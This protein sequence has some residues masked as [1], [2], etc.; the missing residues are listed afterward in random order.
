MKFD[1]ELS[2]ESAS[3]IKIFPEAS[4]SLGY[5]WMGILG[6]YWAALFFGK[7]D[8]TSQTVVKAWIILV[9]VTL[10]LA[11]LAWGKFL[12]HGA[13]VFGATPIPH[14]LWREWLNGVL[15]ATSKLW[16]LAVMSAISLLVVKDLSWTWSAVVALF[17][18][19]L[20]LSMIVA[21]SNFALWHRTWSW[22]IASGVLLI[23]IFI[24]WKNFELSMSAAYGWYL[25]LVFLWPVLLRYFIRHWRQHPPMK[26][27][28]QDGKQFSPLKSALAYFKRY[29]TLDT[30]QSRSGKMQNRKGNALLY[31]LLPLFVPSI[32]ATFILQPWGSR[33]GLPHLMVVGLFALY[34]I[35]AVS[36]K[37]LH[38]RYLLAPSGFRHGHIGTH[39]LIS[40][41][42]M[43]GAFI[44]LVM[45][46]W[47]TF[48]WSIFGITPLRNIQVAAPYWIILLEWIFALSV[49]VA[50]RGA[51]RVSVAG[52]M[53]AVALLLAGLLASYI[54]LFVFNTNV[55]ATW[56]IVGP[57]YAAIL[58]LG[59]IAMM[60]LS[61]RIWT[62]QRL[63]PFIIS[64]SAKAD[65]IIEG[66]RWFP[67]PGRSY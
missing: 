33:A 57:E 59:I 8:N 53:F 20:C 48:S 6:I 67:W 36:C 52:F 60:A 65:D 58:I 46:G 13:R 43:A 24:T 25:P 19:T 26:I 62:S 28:G 35:N 47:F 63:L 7:P 54:L 50:I 21:L 14:A 44:L 49:G 56:F 39:L 41:L 22:S 37:D 2:E 32:F 18:I 5:F 11:G 15:L 42:S 61:N 45:L 27:G 16:V 12:S 17:S 64:G 40:S 34:A 30:A 55:L 51:Q 66:G 23:F 38:W 3:R 31:S 29:T 10:M 4:R 9:A 1:L